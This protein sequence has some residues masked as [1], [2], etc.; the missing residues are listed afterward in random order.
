MAQARKQNTRATQRKR[1]GHVIS[2]Y[3]HSKTM[4]GYR[5]VDKDPIVDII[6]HKIDE[7]KLTLKEIH[8]RGGPVYA[9]LHNW[10]YGA[11]KRP[12]NATIQQLWQAL[13]LATY[14][15]KVDMV[16]DTAKLVKVPPPSV[17]LLKRW[18]NQR[19]KARS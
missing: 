9:T 11:T 17:K 6:A 1:R 16:Y 7:S 10:V 19:R 18:A 3:L 5:F 13:G 12:N 15:G 14:I 8:D 2:A 4:T